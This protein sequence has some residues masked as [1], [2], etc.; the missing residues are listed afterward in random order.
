MNNVPFLRS[1][2]IDRETFQKTFAFLR[3]SPP[4]PPLP[5]NV[6][7][8]TGELLPPYD[9]ERPGVRWIIPKKISANPKHS[10][11]RRII[12]KIKISAVYNKKSKKFVYFK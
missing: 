11:V 2:W 10:G 7:P 3:T 12:P 6:H 1:M 9:P 5:L 4:P 8:D